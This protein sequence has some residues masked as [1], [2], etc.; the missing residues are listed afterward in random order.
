MLALLKE[1]LF[2]T[3]RAVAPLIVVVCVLQFT[4]VRAPAALFLQFFA[5]SVLVTI[6]L[7]LLF[8]GIDLGLPPRPVEPSHEGW[9]AQADVP[10]VTSDLAVDDRGSVKGTVAMSVTPL[11]SSSAWHWRAPC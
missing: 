11:V 4:V 9:T 1:K 8:A 2:E 3:L 10:L 7:L 5:G 6:G